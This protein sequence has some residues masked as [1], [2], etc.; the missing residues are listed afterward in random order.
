MPAE[1]N[2]IQAAYQFASEGIVSLLQVCQRMA[3]VHTG[4]C[5]IA[6]HV[7]VQVVLVILTV[8]HIYLQS[9]IAE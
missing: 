5:C 8:L 6:W 7:L 3:A 9:G 1:F 2:T 4:L